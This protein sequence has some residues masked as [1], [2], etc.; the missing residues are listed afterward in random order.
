MLT[1]Q[2]KNRI[3]QEHCD[4]LER[5]HQELIRRIEDEKNIQREKELQ[6]EYERI[7]EEEEDKLYQDNSD[8]VKYISHDGKPKW[9]LREDFEKKRYKRRRVRKKHK[10]S[11]KKTLIVKGSTIFIILIMIITAVLA[12]RLVAQ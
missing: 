8:Y 12:F 2:E 6:E 1:E 11:L 9:I 7:R 10:R 4:Y 3:K 5:R